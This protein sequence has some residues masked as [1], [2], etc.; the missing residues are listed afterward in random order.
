MKLEIRATSQLLH[1]FLSSSL[2]FFF[3]SHPKDDEVRE[4]LHFIFKGFLENIIFKSLFIKVSYLHDW[5]A[6]AE[7]LLSLDIDGITHKHTSCLHLS[8]LEERCAFN[9]SRF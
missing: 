6:E 2:L 5:K 3:D 4:K 1:A 8:P 9:I 7:I